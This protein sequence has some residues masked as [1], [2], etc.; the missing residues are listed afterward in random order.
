MAKRSAPDFVLL[1]ICGILVLAGILILASVSSS[2]SLQRTGTSFYFLN[3]QLLLG[4]L[5]GL[6]LGAVAFFVPLSRYWRKNRGR[7]P[8][9]LSWTFFI[10]AFRVSKAHF[11]FVYGFLACRPRLFIK[12]RIAQAN[13]CTLCRHHGYSKHV[14]DTSARRGHFG[15][16]RLDWPRDVLSWGNSRMAYVRFSGAWVCFA[17]GSCGDQTLSMA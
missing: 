9:D 2:F 11:Y 17:R 13:P 3:H 10:P 15:S 7:A 1:I 6:L 8:V 14:F 5:P 12:E 16:Y 4:L